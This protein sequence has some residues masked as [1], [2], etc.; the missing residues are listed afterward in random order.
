M[1]K[2]KNNV[3]T[4]EPVP[5]FLIGLALESLAD[6]YW[7]DP[8]LGVQD[9]K[10]L[11]EVDQSLPLGP[12]ERYGA[13][14]LTVG[15]GVV[16]VTRAVVPWSAE[17][18]AADQASKIAS[19]LERIKALRD[20]KIQRGGYKAAGKW[21][22][23]DTFS[24]SQQIGLVILGANIPAGLQWKTMD[25]TFVD[26]TPTLAQQVFQAAAA[27]DNLIFTHAESLRLDVET[28]PDPAAIDI[29]AGWPE[30]FA[31]V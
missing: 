10:W 19:A 25:G 28:A 6:L 3:A 8:E 4:R 1:I 15:D 24:R 27:Q 16:I 23:S 26:M 9:C 30:T 2:V 12:Y 18:I 31:G 13:E 29:K 11:P 7:T 5:N 20:E 17:E 22:H 21:F 14:T